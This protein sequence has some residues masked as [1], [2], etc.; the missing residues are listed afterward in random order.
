MGQL[1]RSHRKAVVEVR[2]PQELMYL[3]LALVAVAERLRDP[4]R[5]AAGYAGMS[6]TLSNLSLRGAGDHYFQRARALLA[7]LPEPP[8]GTLAFV[9]LMG[10]A[11][12]LYQGQWEE[13]HQACAE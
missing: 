7:E 9:A 5:M 11:R 10:W 6:S 1:D 12:T 13:A 2:P 3:V 8:L 4:V